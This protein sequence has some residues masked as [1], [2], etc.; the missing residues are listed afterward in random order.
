MSGGSLDYVYSKV[1]DA[2]STILSYA[3]T[4]QHRAFA[5][6]LQRVSI[7][8]YAIEWVFSGDRALGSE[9]SAIEDC[10]RPGAALDCAIKEA[11]KVL[12]ELSEEIQRAKEIPGDRSS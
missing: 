4:P 5:E 1:D 3:K 7:A 12:A 8:L 9:V 6:H 10:L 11:K 2:A